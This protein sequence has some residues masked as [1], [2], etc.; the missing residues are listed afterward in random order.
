MIPQKAKLEAVK[1]YAAIDGQCRP[2]AMS[3]ALEAALPHL[4]QG[5]VS[6]ESPPWLSDIAMKIA[7]EMESQSALS[8]TTVEKAEAICD[9]LSA[10]SPAPVGV[11][12]LPKGILSLHGN[13]VTFAFLDRDDAETAFWAIDRALASHEPAPT[14]TQEGLSVTGEALMRWSLHTIPATG[15][16]K[17]L[18]RKDGDWVLFD[19]AQSALTACQQEVERLREEKRDA[20]HNG[21]ASRD[22]V[23]NACRTR[24]EA[25]EARAAALEKALRFYADVSKYPA[26]LTGG[27]GD[28][29][30]DC[31]ERARAAL[32]EKSN[33]A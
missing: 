29:W 7:I 9:I 17:M 16:P 3:A 2:V 5:E 13:N 23:V 10:L 22:G 14:D 33:E 31:G 12:S 15:A 1:A 4:S 18:E 6:H 19:D 24:A 28:L 30:S 11:T 20:Y 21:Y 27:M 32:K 26:P 8:T 25:A